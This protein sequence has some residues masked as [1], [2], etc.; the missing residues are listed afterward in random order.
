MASL[1]TCHEELV[2]WDGTLLDTQIYLSIK[3]DENW[4]SER[5]A[6][7]ACVADVGGWMNRNMLTLT[8]EKANSM[9]FRP[10]T[11][12]VGRT[13]CPSRSEADYY[14]LCNP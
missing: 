9:S 14:I 11:E 3:P 5:S 13:T 7:E 4:A 8:Q 12:F 6:T 10:N 1:S 2:V